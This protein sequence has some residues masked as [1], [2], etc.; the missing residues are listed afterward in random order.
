MYS[1]PE[2]LMVMATKTKKRFVPGILYAGMIFATLLFFSCKLGLGGEVDL[3]AP[4][5]AITSHQNLDYVGVPCILSGT[6]RDNVRV[7]TVK[8]YDGR[9]N[10]LYGNASIDGE[11]WHVELNLP[12]GD[13]AL[14]VVAYDG[15]DNSSYESVKQL[16]LMVD[17]TPP[18]IETVEIRRPGG[19]IQYLLEREVLEAADPLDYLAADSFQNE[20]FSLNAELDD[21]SNIDNATVNLLDS[22]GTVLFSKVSTESSAFNP[23]WTITHDELVAINPAHATGRHYF[24]ITVDTQDAAGNPTGGIATNTDQFLW[25]CWYPESDYPRINITTASDGTITIPKDASMPVEFWDDDGLGIAHA[26]LMPLADWNALSGSTDNDKINSLIANPS[27]STILGASQNLTGNPR[28]RVVKIAAGTQSGSF[29]LVLLC[30]DEKTTSANL[31]YGRSIPVQ[32]TDEDS[33]IVI[34]DSPE[35]NTFPT[36]SSGTEFIIDGA[37]L[38]NRGATVLRAAWIPAGIPDQEAVLESTK[39]ALRNSTVASGASETLPNGVVLRGVPLSGTTTRTVDGQ[40]YYS[41]DFSISYDIL[42]SFTY[43]GVNENDAKLFVF[44]TTDEDENDEWRIFR[45]PGNSALPT[46]T[47][48]YPAQDLQVHSNET[49]FPLSFT[50]T[51][52]GNLPLDSVILQDTSGATPVAETFVQTGTDFTMT[53]TVADMAGWADPERRTWQVTVRDIL[54]NESMQSRT[55]IFT[56]IPAL[57]RITSGAINGTFKEGDEIMLQAVFSNAVRVPAGSEPRL[58]LRYSAGDT[59][60]KYAEYHS[61]SGTNTLYFRF[62]VPAG[63]QSADLRSW[64]TPIDLDGGSILSTEGSGTAAH[65]P[66][67]N[68]HPVFVN[69]DGNNLQDSK[70]IALDGI[71]P[72]ISGLSFTDR[73]YREGETIQFSLTLNEPPLVS[74]DPELRLVGRIAASFVRTAG[75]TVIFEYTVQASENFAS[76]GWNLLTCMIETDRLMITDLAGNPLSLSTTGTG[77]AGGIDTGIP[78]APVIQSPAAR[79]YNTDQNLILNMPSP[80]GSPETAEYSLDGGLTWNSYTVPV[81]LADGEYVIT[82]R[83]IDAA[84]NVSPIATPRAVEIGKTFPAII[85]ISCENPD[86]VYT[87]DDVLTFKVS[88]DRPVHT[89][90]AAGLLTFA[91]GASTLTAAIRESETDTTA[92]YFERIIP[93]G[94]E[95][96]PVQISA[97][98]LSG[99]VDHFGNTNATPT[100]TG[101]YTMRPTLAVD[102]ASP[103]VASRAPS[104]GAV[105]SRNGS[106]ESVLTLTFNENVWVESG[107]IKVYR[108]GAWLIPPVLTE[109]EFAA[110]YYNSALTEAQRTALMQTENGSPA[111]HP[112]TGQPLG[113]YKKTTHGLKLQGGSWVPDTATK[114]VLAFETGLDNAAIRAAF[115]AAD[116]HRYVIDVTSFRVT[117]SGTKTITVVLPEPLPHGREWACDI[118]AESFRDGGGNTSAAESWQFWSDKTATPVVRIDRYSQGEGAVQPL[119]TATYN[120][121]DILTAGSL[122]GEETFGKRD[123]KTVPSGYVRVRIDCETPNAEIS[124]AAKRE[125][126]A[127]IT[128]GG[129]AANTT[130]KSANADI[131]DTELA[132]LADLSA[133]ATAMTY[134]TYFPLGDGAIDTA[135]KYYV[136]ASATKEASGGEPA[137]ADSDRGYEGA[138]KSVIMYRE[139]GSGGS[140][141]RFQGS[142]I[143]GGMPTISGFPLRDA[144][145]DLRFTKHSYEKGDDWYW[146]SWEIVCDWYNQSARTNWQTNDNY[147][148]NTYGDYLYAY[149]KLYYGGGPWTDAQ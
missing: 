92:L 97:L 43:E 117:G 46:V 140:Y 112:L 114:Y 77:S 1:D 53:K 134:K 52:P 24:R 80:G 79:A 125:S 57:T 10:K 72:V 71:P 34:V 108:S 81:L 119:A 51:T 19:W 143:E 104:A 56:R 144:D 50:I 100:I 37:I 21:E 115:E 101:R 40:V 141:T 132:S 9:T 147:L 2:G 123:K 142:N 85:A 29:R 11:N 31:W 122:T 18:V 5:L 87:E 88:F 15:N 118:S 59:V 127:T 54:G 83:R 120:A 105:L 73:W 47:F 126:T 149:Q 106:G 32:V 16:T 44:Y 60:D 103:Q 8:V 91:G 98:N 58:R 89:T 82:A 110:V 76:I 36:I 96:Y 86:G 45:L 128:T 75:T 33:P 4:V 121:G 6:A 48:T 26:R 113:P 99:V 25:L 23:V 22:S 68:G 14:R 78:P 111:L 17:S 66:G 67:I 38:D 39:E 109:S 69:G 95:M 145:P 135:G 124:F 107:T 7:Q 55:V 74:G 35:E 139:P 146:H 12:E 30:R 28:Q 94:S 41:R 20:Q 27:R 133:L 70:N 3:Q 137:L 63:A 131:S 42:N 90:S 62:I 129:L 13:T 148:F 136:A 116:Y 64:T 84:G 130:R 102:S 49:A 93:A 61:G 65:L 138:F